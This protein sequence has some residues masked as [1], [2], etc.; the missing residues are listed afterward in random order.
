MEKPANIA[1]IALVA[2]VAAFDYFAPET[3]S[4]A[5]DRALERPVGRFFAMGAVAITGAH[6]LNVLPKR[7]DPLHQLAERVHHGHPELA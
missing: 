4:E 6:L 5:F 2:G 3:L 1:W 7:V